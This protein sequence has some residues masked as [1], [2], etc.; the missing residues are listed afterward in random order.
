M[1]VEACKHKSSS[2]YFGKT[3]N[4]VLECQSYEKNIEQKDETAQM[5]IW[6]P[7]CFRSNSTISVQPTAHASIRAVQ[8]F[9]IQHQ[10]KLMNVKKSKQT[11]KKIKKQLLNWYQF[12]FDQGSIWLI[13]FAFDDM[14]SLE[15][16]D[17]IW[18]NSKY[19]LKI[20]N[21]QNKL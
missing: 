6:I 11:W 14:P 18:M 17:G 13:R 10:I 1:T 4:F 15:L 19:D 3:P 20:L 16:F 8:N 7:F 2:K 9:L 5:S 21:D 12:L